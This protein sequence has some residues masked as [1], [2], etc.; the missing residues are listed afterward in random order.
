LLIQGWWGWCTSTWSGG[1]ASKKEKRPA[2]RRDGVV[3]S[4][5][6]E[7]NDHQIC[8][9]AWSHRPAAQPHHNLFR[10]FR[11][12][13]GCT[14][15][16]RKSGGGRGGGYRVVLDRERHERAALLRPF[17]REHRLDRRALVVEE[18][19]GEPHL[20][21]RIAGGVHVQRCSAPGRAPTGQPGGEGHGYGPRS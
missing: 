21:A 2:M 13:P 1:G 5:C 15:G 9:T 12:P 3:A 4:P 10:P 14:N 19:H 20:L 16:R 7:K 18:V 17:Q 8:A 6:R 11:P